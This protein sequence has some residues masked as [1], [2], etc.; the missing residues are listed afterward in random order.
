MEES[1]RTSSAAPAPAF[2]ATAPLRPDAAPAAAPP[3]GEATVISGRPAATG[4]PASMAEIGRMLEGHSLGPYRL[5]QFVGGGGMGAVFRAL[6]TTLDRVVAVKVL[7]R[8]QS[9]DEEM[10][11]RFRNEAQSAARLD[12]ENI[13]RVHAV[14]S[15][16]GWHYIVFEFIEGTNLR[17]VVVQEGP[18]DLARTIDV[19]IQVAEALE[20]ASERDVVHRDIKPSNII[21][22]PAGRA[23]VVDMGLAR[24]HHMAGDQDLTVSGMT[25]GTFDYISPEQ[26]RDPRSADVRSDLYS[27]GCT[28]F[29]ML[30]GRPPFANGTMVQKLLQHQQDSPPAIES[31]RPDVPKRF[32]AILGQLMEKDPKDRYQRPAE[33][34]ADLVAIAEDLGIELSTPRPTATPATEP[35]PRP[36]PV[37]LPWLLPLLGLLAVVGSLWLRAAGNARQ[38]VNGAARLSG[39][40]ASTAP[41]ASDGATAS[42]AGTT[43]EPRVW[44]VVDVPTVDDDCGTVGEAVRQASDGDVIEVACAEPRDDGPFTIEGKQLT[45]RAAPGIEPILRFSETGGATRDGGCVAVVSGTLELRDLTLRSAFLPAGLGRPAVVS[46]RGSAELVCESVVFAVPGEGAIGGVCVRSEMSQDER[47]EIHA[48]DTRAEGGAA[49]LETKGSGRIDLFWSGGRV[50]TQGRF[51]LAEGAPR[52][53]GSGMSVRMTLDDGLFACGDGFACLLDSP[54][55]PVAPR[56]QAFAKG[57]RFLVPEGRAVLQQS[58]VGDPE[59]YRPAVEWIDAASRYEGS[60]ILRRIDGAAERFDIDFASQPQPFNHAATIDGWPAD[61]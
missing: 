50:V 38:T 9:N 44:R 3:A 51:L 40:A 53:N 52:K 46:L 17:D 5:D 59:A 55:L 42:P 19:T 47:Q 22:T 35:A 14:G 43:T 2:D 29:F 58:G 57:C 48:S 28:V 61:D 39:S 23:R 32:G 26:A 1:S 36:V 21:I 12:H 11:K 6:D 56:L 31:L 10:L 8:Q 15:D 54:S 37:H 16:D 30:V 27:L 25:L 45:I 13:G 33:L 4:K 60:G 34:I 24:L 20:H 7:S 41:D 18:F 49:F